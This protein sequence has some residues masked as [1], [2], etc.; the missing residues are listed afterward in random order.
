MNAPSAREVGEGLPSLESTASK[1]PRL[2]GLLDRVP[3]H[4]KEL[5]ARLTE[6]Y[7][8]L[9][10]HIQ[11]TVVG[12][13]ISFRSEREVGKATLYLDE[14]QLE[15]SPPVLD[16]VPLL[17]GD[18]HEDLVMSGRLELTL[19]VLIATE[20]DIMALQNVIEKAYFLQSWQGRSRYRPRALPRSVS[21]KKKPPS[22]GMGSKAKPF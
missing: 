8:R 18:A 20:S 12:N 6:L 10:P 1:N 2:A 7:L 17:S 13:A 11:L 19:K 16:S 9:D 22:K 21:P 5:V 14:I 4:V 15:L 3:D